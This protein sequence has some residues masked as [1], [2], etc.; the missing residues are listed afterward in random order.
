MIWQFTV[1]DFTHLLVHQKTNTDVVYTLIGGSTTIN[2]M[3]YAIF[4]GP[5]KLKIKP[6]TLVIYCIVKVI[7]QEIKNKPEN[8]AM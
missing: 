6:S 5:P 4:G 8:I 2:I 7:T 3:V 1:P